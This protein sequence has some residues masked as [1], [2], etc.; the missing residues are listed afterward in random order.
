MKSHEIEKKSTK[1]SQVRKTER[2][3]RN[4]GNKTATN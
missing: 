4:K 2:Q 3:K 1:G